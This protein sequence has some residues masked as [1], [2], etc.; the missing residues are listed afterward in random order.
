[1]KFLKPKFWDKNQVSFFSIL[2]FPISLCVRFF[3]FLKHLFGK[4]YKFSIPVICVG[5]IYLGGTGKTPFCIELFYILKKLNK[6]PS[7]IK[8]KYKSLHDE[9]TLLE[10]TGKTYEGANRILALN[11][12]INNKTDVA[13]LDDGF[14]DF[15]FKKDL[16]IICFNEKQWVGNGFVL[17]S[18][19]LRESLSALNRAN[20]VIINGNKNIKIENEILKNNKLIKIF[21]TKFKPQNIDELKNKKVTCFAG[22]GNP[23]NFFNILKENSVNIIQHISFPDHYNYSKTELDNLKEIAKKNNTI[24][25]TTEKD[26]CRIY[27]EYRESIKYLKITTEI[28]N[29]NQFIEEIK[30]FI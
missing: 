16:S 4:E 29:Q 7:F 14:Q 15:S 3:S 22:I 17:P 10:K 20:F 28:Q 6:N 11:E 18:G 5:N 24:L 8:K 19:P 13:I 21:Y 23:E 30:K 1:M 9:V 27:R 2:L 26:Y 25:L 12:A